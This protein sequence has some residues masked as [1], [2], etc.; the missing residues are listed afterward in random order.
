[1][2]QQFTSKS[3]KEQIFE[4]TEIEDIP[5]CSKGYFSVPTENTTSLFTNI[6]K[7]GQLSS[8]ILPKI[9]KLKNKVYHDLYQKGYCITDG[10]K[11]GSNFLIYKGDP[12]IYHAEAIIHVVFVD[13]SYPLFKFISWCRLA[14]TVKKNC[15][16]AFKKK[17]NIFYLQMNWL[18]NSYFQ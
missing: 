18:R 13:E 17:G 11:F 15:L 16:F 8:T 14:N 4:I 9:V 3:P 1:M 5:I 2:S 7:G 6:Y 12:S 10:S